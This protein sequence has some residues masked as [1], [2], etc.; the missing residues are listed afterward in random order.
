MHQKLFIVIACFFIF[1]S[2]YT[3][4]QAV[5]NTGEEVLLF[6]N[7]TW[8]YKNDSSAKSWKTILDTFTFNKSVK[9]NFLLKSEKN[10]YGICCPLA[11]W[12]KV[13]YRWI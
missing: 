8:K 5:T 9:S 13:V 6:E 3:Q 2:A 4:I 12:P 1:Q 10:S 7:G 11:R